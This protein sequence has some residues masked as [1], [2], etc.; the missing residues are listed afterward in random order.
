MNYRLRDNLSYCVIGNH[1]VFLDVEADRYFTLPDSMEHAF[2]THI[3]APGRGTAPEELVGCGLLVGSSEAD[4]V[5][6]GIEGPSRSAQEVPTTRDQLGI[7]IIAE[8]T[9][10]LCGCRRKLRTMPL[11]EVLNEAASYRDS[12]CPPGT[13]VTTHLDEQQ[14]LQTAGAFERAR[15]YIPVDMCCLPDSL[16]LLRFLSRRRLHCNIVF[17]VTYDPFSAHCWVQFHDIALNETVGAAKAH[18]VIRVV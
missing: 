14:L 5:P 16:A 11:K 1:A 18:T 8:V 6:I 17:G 4:V 13:G 2:L 12:R 7:K 3:G 15:R 10:T 9:T